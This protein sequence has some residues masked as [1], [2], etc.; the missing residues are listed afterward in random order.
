MNRL[1]KKTFDKG[2]FEGKWFKELRE[3]YGITDAK[4]IY[5][6]LKEYE[7]IEEL[8]EKIK[9]QTVYQKIYNGYNSQYI[10]EDR[11]WDCSISYNFEARMIEIYNYE[12]IDGLKVDD[13][14]KMWSFDR[15]E[16]ENE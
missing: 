3:M 9:T 16:L 7:D 12:C 15:R 1:T 2:T 4:K 6:K 13:Y 14:G 11:F 10:T 8:C 5:L